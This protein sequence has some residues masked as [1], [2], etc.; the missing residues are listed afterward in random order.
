MN[1]KEAN[2]SEIF[3]SI[4]GEGPLAGL[5]FLFVRFGGCNLRCSYCDT[6]F[7][8]KEVTHCTLYRNGWKEKIKNPVSLEKFSSLI[9]SFDFRYISLTGGEPLLQS[10]FI[11]KAIESLKDKILLME[12]NGSLPEDLTPGLI[13]RVDYWSVDIKLPSSS[14]E[15]CLEEN[16]A[17]L[18]KLK[19]ARNIILKTVFSPRTP[20]D[21][22]KKAAI[23]ADKLFQRNKNITLIFQPL[24]Q[25]KK[26]RVGS[27][28]EFIYSLMQKSPI[29]IRV[30][31]QMHKMLNVL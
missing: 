11:E 17:F 23:I 1:E 14:S 30:L 19:K 10:R 5:P 24:S 31:P 28:L 16:E 18:M 4:Q 7:S 21:E 13:S 6:K 27:N 29:E 25:G 12:T 22:L 8:R 15:K 2:I 20:N 26:M 3:F 9:S